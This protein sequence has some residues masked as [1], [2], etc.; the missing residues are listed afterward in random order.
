MKLVIYRRYPLEQIVKADRYVEKGHT[1][2]NV[3]ITYK[4]I[5]KWQWLDLNQRP[6]SYPTIATNEI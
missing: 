5:S 4:V 2:R 3:A 1:K 6:I